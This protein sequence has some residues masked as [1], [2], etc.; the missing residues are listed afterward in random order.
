MN[1]KTKNLIIVI[2]GIVL[3]LSVYALLMY[4]LAD[5]NDLDNNSGLRFD[6]DNLYYT[7]PSEYPFLNANE[8]KTNIGRAVGEILWETR[9]IDV[10][11]VGVILLVAA[12]S[13]S[14]MV[15]GIEVKSIGTRLTYL[16]KKQTMTYSSWRI[17]SCIALPNSKWQRS[18]PRSIRGHD[19]R[20]LSTRKLT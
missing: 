19:N 18:W 5:F 15:K 20:P 2:S 4:G 16:T 13:A 7:R 10:I 17:N 9:A 12:E 1:K 8:S 14:A 3:S 11:L 6:E